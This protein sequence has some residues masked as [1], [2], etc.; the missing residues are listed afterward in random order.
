MAVGRAGRYDLFA[1]P[2]NARSAVEQALDAADRPARM[3]ARSGEVMGLLAHGH[4][5]LEGKGRLLMTVHAELSRRAGFGIAWERI[6]KADYLG[7]PTAELDQPGRGR[8]DALLLPHIVRPA[9]DLPRLAEQLRQHPGRPK[10]SSA[11]PGLP[12]ASSPTRSPPMGMAPTLERSAQCWAGGSPTAPVFI[13]T[14]GSSRITAASRA[15]SDVCAG[16]KSFTPAERFCQ[17]YDELRNHLRPRARHNQHVPANRRRVLH[18]R[19]ATT[20]LAILA[21]G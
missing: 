20:A 4:P 1:P 7:A 21:A 16:F 19:R 13:R 8:L 2:L 5:V 3:S 11:R 15:A 18:L 17:A 6:G 10:P 12:P 14:T 9:P